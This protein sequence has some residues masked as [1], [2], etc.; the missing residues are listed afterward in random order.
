LQRSF[1][2]RGNHRAFC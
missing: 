1:S 2:C